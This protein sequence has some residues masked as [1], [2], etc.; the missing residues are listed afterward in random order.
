MS[1]A[2]TR[3]MGEKQLTPEPRDRDSP[4]SLAPSRRFSDCTEGHRVLCNTALVPILCVIMTLATRTRFLV[5]A[6]QVLVFVLS[7]TLLLEVAAR[8]FEVPGEPERGLHRRRRPDIRRVLVD[9]GT[10]ELRNRDPND[11]HRSTV[12]DQL[13]IQHPCRAAEA[14]APEPIADHHD[15]V[16]KR[17]N[18]RAEQAPTC[19]A[20][21]RSE[22]IA[23][24]KCSSAD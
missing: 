6:R 1:G 22:K 12:D 13:G 23:G 24:N 11:R 20:S 7:A 8:A 17:P 14:A 21:Q 9:G 4:G 19:P 15:R 5:Q 3:A 18:V 2:S 10:D 16:L